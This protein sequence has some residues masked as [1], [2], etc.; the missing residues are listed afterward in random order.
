MIHRMRFMVGILDVTIWSGR[1]GMVIRAAIT[2]ITHVLSGG[3]L[4]IIRTISVWWGLRRPTRS[5]WTGMQQHYTLPYEA[6]G[7]PNDF[8][9]QLEFTLFSLSTGRAGLFG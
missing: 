1:L 4:I 9:I 5:R 8:V 6:R 3:R 7:I 2:L